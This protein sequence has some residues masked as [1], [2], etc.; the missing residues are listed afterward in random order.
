MQDYERR[1]TYN[2]SNLQ[3]TR[4]DSIFSTFES[5]IKQLVTV[6]IKGCEL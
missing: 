6:C 5:E 2:M 4:S 1:A 3:I